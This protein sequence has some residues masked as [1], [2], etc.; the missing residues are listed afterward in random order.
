MKRIL[1]IG[2]GR[3]SSTLVKY[4]EENSK[5]YGWEI[6]VGDRDINLVKEK[7]DHP[8]RAI[9]FDV[10]DENALYAFLVHTFMPDGT[11]QRAP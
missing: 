4:L 7:V 6:T 2:A 9:A 1:I 11:R 3:S 5:I 10:F 8:T